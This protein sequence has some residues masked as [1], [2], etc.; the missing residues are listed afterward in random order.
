MHLKA[1][2]VVEEAPQLLVDVAAV[3]VSGYQELSTAAAAAA[4]GA[5]ARQ[6]QL[7]EVTAGRENR[8]S[9]KAAAVEPLKE[10]AAAAAE[11]E[12]VAETFA[13]STIG[14]ARR[15]A[16]ATAEQDPGPRQKALESPL[17]ESAERARVDSLKQHEAEF[18]SADGALLR[19]A[20]LLEP[21]GAG[22]IN[23]SVECAVCQV[24][25]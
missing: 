21:R 9:A 6:C 17:A 12:E 19:V 23:A 10:V 4:A 25:R 14:A 20:T 24:P 7:G 1:A 11:V 8:S 16:R 22:A 3:V 15:L 2:E 13:R 5:P 18:F